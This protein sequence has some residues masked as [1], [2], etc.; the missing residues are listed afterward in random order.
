MSRAL[1]SFPCDCRK[2]PFRAT[3]V[4][5]KQRQ[6]AGRISAQ[7]ALLP[8]PLAVCCPTCGAILGWK[9]QAL[10]RACPAQGRMATF[11]GSLLSELKTTT[12]LVHSWLV[13]L[14]AAARLRVI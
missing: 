7:R 11:D 10:A 2:K 12:R 8:L 4:S 14:Q 13:V 3:C 6:S 1:N 5:P 9:C